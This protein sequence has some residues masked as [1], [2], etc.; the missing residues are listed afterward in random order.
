MF[1]IHDSTGATCVFNDSVRD[2]VSLAHATTD[3][4]WVC[5]EVIRL[6]DGIFL[7]LHDHL[8]RLGH[9][10]LK[11]FESYNI[12]YEYIIDVLLKLKANNNLSTGNVKLLLAFRYT[13]PPLPDIIAYPV[14]HRYPLESEIRQGVKTSLFRMERE[15]PNIKVLNTAQQELYRKALAVRKV[16]E[17]L[18]VDDHGCVTEGSKSNL[19]MIRQGSV[20]TAPGNSVLKGITRE[21]VM[22][23][24]R[25]LGYRLSEEKISTGSLDRYDAAFITG[26]SPKVLP[27]AAIDE[28]VYNPKH[29]VLE[30]IREQYDKLI[31]DYVAAVRQ[32]GYIGV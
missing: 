29:P 20:C 9:S 27:V 1:S 22:A 13:T 23:L 16:Y 14:V 10:V 8:N 24:C 5:Y 18:L 11:M 19:F 15:N 17:V 7:F 26:T 32:Q 4:A 12:D 28:T 21:K 30:H 3:Y 6:V 25:S 31:E 2:T